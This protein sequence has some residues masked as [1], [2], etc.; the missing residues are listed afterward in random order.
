MANLPL[1]DVPIGDYGAE[2]A[3]MAHYRAEGEHRALALGNRGPLRFDS[4]G[5]LWF[6]SP[7]DPAAIARQRGLP[8][9]SGAFGYFFSSA[10]RSSRRSAP[11]PCRE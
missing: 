8:R 1:I 3:A 9:I 4:E 10:A 11:W 6:A 2:E 5:R 7:A